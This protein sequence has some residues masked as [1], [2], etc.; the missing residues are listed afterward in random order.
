MI[1]LVWKRITSKLFQNLKSALS[2]EVS[3]FL[4]G[5][6]LYM[7]YAFLNLDIVLHTQMETLKN[8]AAHQTMS[9]STW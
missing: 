2:V 8:C 9:L 1:L 3:Q 4:L 7:A 5:M 6:V